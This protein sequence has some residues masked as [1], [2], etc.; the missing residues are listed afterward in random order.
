MYKGVLP[1]L[2]TPPTPVFLS[3]P[4]TM[5]REAE[6]VGLPSASR[7]YGLICSRSVRLIR[8]DGHLHVD[9]AANLLG[10]AL[11]TGPAQELCQHQTDG[12]HRN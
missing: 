3:Q 2:A 5:K 6:G 10:L 8:G 4:Q 1:I 12:H 7:S 11:Q 9:V